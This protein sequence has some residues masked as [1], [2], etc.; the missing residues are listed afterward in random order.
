MNLVEFRVYPH[1]C[2]SFVIRTFM[3]II[4]LIVIRTSK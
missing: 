1:E 4:Y 3:L 2:R